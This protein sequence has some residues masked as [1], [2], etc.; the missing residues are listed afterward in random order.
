[1]SEGLQLRKNS[2]NLKKR[3]EKERRPKD[4]RNQLYTLELTSASSMQLY[5]A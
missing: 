2:L 3:E 1:M 4:D 5:R